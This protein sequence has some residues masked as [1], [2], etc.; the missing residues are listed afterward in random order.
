MQ[1]E[2]TNKR[3]D[4]KRSEIRMNSRPS[5]HLGVSIG[6]HDDALFDLFTEQ[7]GAYSLNTVH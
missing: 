6:S 5:E 1:R 7:P 2:E 3:R 4:K